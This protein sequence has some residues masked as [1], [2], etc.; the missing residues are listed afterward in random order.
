MQSSIILPCQTFRAGG[1]AKSE[2][3]LHSHAWIATTKVKIHTVGDE[4]VEIPKANA[5]T[6]VAKALEK[7]TYPERWTLGSF[8]WDGAMF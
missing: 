4:E 6:L 7:Y 2:D 8:N 1:G 3:F 5:D